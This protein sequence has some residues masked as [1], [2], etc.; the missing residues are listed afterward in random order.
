VHPEDSFSYDMFSQVAQALRESGQPDPL[1][2]LTAKYVIAMGESRSASR[3]LTYVN[4]IHPL[5]NIYDAYLLHSRTGSSS[6]LS[7]QP[8]VDIATPD[9]VIVREDLNVPVIS[10][11]TETDPIG[12]GAIRS[13]Q[14]DSAM[15]RLWEVAG[16][17]HGDYYNYVSGREDTGQGA[18]FALVVEEGSVLGF[19]QCERPMNAGP[20]SWVLNSALSSLDIWVRDGTRPPKAQRLEVNDE[21][22]AYLKDD[23][24]NVLGGIRTSYVD[25]PAAIL[26]GEAMDNGFILKA[27]GER[28]KAAAGLQWDLLGQ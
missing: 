18:E 20:M 11:Q 7:Q 3:L 2:G 1:Q 8:E 4:A 27:D 9:V 16:T 21:T 10:F 26:S 28:I 23:L 13:R 17:A 15:F 22:I 25:A 14:D 5:Y 6:S 12:L 24:G 19:I